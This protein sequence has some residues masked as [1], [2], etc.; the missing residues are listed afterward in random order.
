MF[1][2]HFLFYIIYHVLYVYLE[3]LVE[4]ALIVVALYVNQDYCHL[5]SKKSDIY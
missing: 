4:K 1:R 5:G 2:E 3:I